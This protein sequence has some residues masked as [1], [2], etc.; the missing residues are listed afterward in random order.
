MGKEDDYTVFY[1]MSTYIKP[2]WTDKIIVP[3]A[4][5]TILNFQRVYM[6]NNKQLKDCPG[7]RNMIFRSSLMFDI[8]QNGH[9]MNWL[10]TCLYKPQNNLPKYSLFNQCAC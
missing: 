3:E 8:N 4:D 6:H 5:Y 10:Y 9:A 2:A 1:W 7:I